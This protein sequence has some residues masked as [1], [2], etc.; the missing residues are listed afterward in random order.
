MAEFFCLMTELAFLDPNPSGSP[1]VLLLHGLGVNASSWTLQFPPLIEAG[2][3]PLAPDAPGFG[4]S[5][6]DG[7]GWSLKRVAAAM[8]D[9][10]HE[11]VIGP[12]HVV[13]ISMGA[14]VA[15][16]FTLDY[17]NKVKRLVLVSAF[18]ALRPEQL[19]GWLYFLRRALLVSFK[20]IP[21]QAEFV[22]RRLFPAPGQEALRKLLIEQVTQAD[23]RAYRAAMRAL[24]LFDT[25]RRLRQITAPTL[26]IGGANDGTVSPSAQKILAEG[27]PDTRQVIIPGGG[28]AVSVDHPEEFNRALLEF[29]C[30]P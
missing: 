24:A 20:G 22:S 8:T 9:L 19:S 3:R 28:H 10:L 30:A 16:Q 14:A 26:V 18:A 13:G 6:Y 5:R 17:P 12:V 4:A 21:A 1:G 25:R 27:I 11:L 23:P 7:R 2:F 15:Q 29:L